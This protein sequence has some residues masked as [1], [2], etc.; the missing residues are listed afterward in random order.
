MFALRTRRYGGG[1]TC[2][3]N[4][5]LIDHRLLIIALASCA[6]GHRSTL[7]LQASG[8]KVEQT[9]EH[10][11]PV[12]RTPSVSLEVF[13]HNLASRLRPVSIKAPFVSLPTR[14]QGVEAGNMTWIYNSLPVSLFTAATF[15]LF[16]RRSQFTPGALSFPQSPHASPG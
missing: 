12:Q 16:K 2:S 4:L 14:P 13:H 1:G 7:C 9:T 6:Y 3:W 8:G 15:V 10:L 5:F 11:H